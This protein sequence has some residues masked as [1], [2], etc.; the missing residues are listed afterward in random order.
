M[1]Q[2]SWVAAWNPEVWKGW[3][4]RL[5]LRLVLNLLWWRWVAWFQANTW[6]GTRHGKMD[7]NWIWMTAWNPIQLLKNNFYLQK[8][9]NKFCEPPKTISSQWG[10][11]W[12]SPNRYCHTGSMSEMHRPEANVVS[13]ERH[14]RRIGH[15]FIPWSRVKMKISASPVPWW[16]CRR[17]GGGLTVAVN[18]MGFWN[19]RIDAMVERLR[20]FGKCWFWCLKTEE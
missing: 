15:G 5:T 9:R 2:K 18:A 1:V 6:E 20:C 17:P 8:K 16:S 19:C 3:M 4:W 10:N 12:W 7:G 13:L 11:P 14:L